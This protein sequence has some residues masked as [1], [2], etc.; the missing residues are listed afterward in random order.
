MESTENPNGGCSAEDVGYAKLA[1]QIVK[2][3]EAGIFRKFKLL[4]VLNALRLQAELV[5]LEHELQDVLQEDLDSDDPIR[6]EYGTCF[7]RM[8]EYVDDGDSTQYELLEDI[9][10]KLVQYS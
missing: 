4:H 3:P 9:R 10:V 7:S 8:R 2:T 1:H 5:S 6:R